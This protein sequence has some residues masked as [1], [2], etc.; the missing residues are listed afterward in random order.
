MVFS[1]RYSVLLICLTLLAGCEPY[2]YDIKSSYRQVSKNVSQ[3]ISSLGEKI[4]TV[5]SKI[6]SKKNALEIN[7]IQD[8]YKDI[9]SVEDLLTKKDNDQIKNFYKQDMPF[10]KILRNVISNHPEVLAA[11]YLEK[12]AEQDIAASK[13]NTKPQITGSLNAGGIRENINSSKI[14]SGVGVN[15]GISQLIYYGGQVTS[16]IG[17]KEALLEKAKAHKMSVKGRVGFE[18]SNAWID[19]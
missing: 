2:Q 6:V 17:K 11:Q 14:T 13:G 5:G 8:R 16:G 9:D 7:L 1:F 18:A 19:L 12:A 15:A 4:N 10:Q 3:T